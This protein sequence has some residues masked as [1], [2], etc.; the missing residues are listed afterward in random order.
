MVGMNAVQRENWF[1]A[2]SQYVRRRPEARKTNAATIWMNRT[3]VITEPPGAVQ[4]N[5]GPLFCAGDT[6][7]AGGGSDNGLRVDIDL[8]AFLNGAPDVVLTHEVDG[9]VAVRGMGGAP[10]A[11]RG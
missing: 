5:T 4:L 2:N 11:S 3:T 9:L 7:V 1:P 8:L 10:G 6:N